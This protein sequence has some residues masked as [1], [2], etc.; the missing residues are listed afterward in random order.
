MS[1]YV[2]TVTL[3]DHLGRLPVPN[4]PYWL[5]NGTDQTQIVMSAE[6]GSAAFKCSVQSLYISL[7]RFMDLMFI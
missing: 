5:L 1:V 6:V 7:S 2:K 3:K 4:S